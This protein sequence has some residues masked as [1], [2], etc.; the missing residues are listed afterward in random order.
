MRTHTA[1]DQKNAQESVDNP[2]A[3]IGDDRNQQL[4][5]DELLVVFVQIEFRV[6][7]R[8][9]K[10]VFSFLWFLFVKKS[11][12]IQMRQTLASFSVFTRH[13]KVRQ[14]NKFKY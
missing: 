7:D 11:R 5:P 14:N 6:R 3:A 13:E 8:L 10:I 4:F 9:G 2:P 1:P 12:Q